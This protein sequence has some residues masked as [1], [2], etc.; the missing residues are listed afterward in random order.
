[1]STDV[2]EP[3]ADVTVPGTG[4]TKAHELFRQSVRQFID[5]E[6][7]PYVDEWEDAEIFP[8]HEVF[9]KA[10]DLGL[11]GLSYPE[12]YGGMGADYWYNIALSEELAHI[13]GGSIPMAMSVQTDMATPALNTYG[14]HELKERFLAPAIAGDAVC[15]IAVTE[16]GAGS[17][18]AAIRTKAV[19]DGNDYVINGSKL[20]ITNG[21]QADFIV[22]LAK[23]SQHPGYRSMSL[24]VV[25]TD[26]E[27]FQVTK[28]LKKLGNWA[29][30]TAELAFDN[31]RVP[32]ENRIGEEGM[33]F[34]YQMEQFQNERLVSSAGCAAG[35]EKILKMTIDYCRGREAFGKPLI[36]N[37]WIAFKLSEMISETEFLRQ[38]CYHCVRKMEAGQDYTREA[39]MAKLKAGRLAREVADTCMQFHGGMGYMEEYPLARYYRDSRLWSIG[40]GADEVMLGIIAKLE[41]ITPKK[42]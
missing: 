37:Q 8:A 22:L 30:D 3:R 14:T 41:G 39:S 10:G 11:L 35:A 13:N 32:V 20:Y 7:N 34:I 12:E 27:G 26:T 18:V 28:K 31:V 15:S 1:M 9:K 24:I 6:I 36:E 42:K 19:R 33:G 17:D 25:P 16:P 23:T 29:S 5:K 2:L 40:A 21:V 38:M 4:F